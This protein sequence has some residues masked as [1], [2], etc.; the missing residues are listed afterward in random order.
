MS[1]AQHKAD[2]LKH[3]LTQEHL[4]RAQAVGLSAADIIALIAQYGPQ[5]ASIIIAILNRIRPPGGG[6]GGQPVPTP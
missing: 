6:G 2:L 3:G 5:A 4:D 1:N